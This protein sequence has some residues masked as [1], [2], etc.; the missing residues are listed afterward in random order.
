MKKSDF[1]TLVLGVVGGLLFSL[2]MCMCLLPE[3]NVFREGVVVTA[4]GALTLVILAIVRFRMVGKKMKKINW[5]TV[6]KV[7]YGIFASLVLGIGLSLVLVAGEYLLGI[8]LGVAG[9]VLLLCLIPMC[10]GLHK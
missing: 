2:G 6:G 7:L 4:A 10:V 1:I 9:I 8:I 5:K 3:W